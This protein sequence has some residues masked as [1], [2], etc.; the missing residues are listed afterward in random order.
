MQKYTCKQTENAYLLR[1]F[2]VTFV[3]SLSL[4]AIACLSTKKKTDF[5]SS[6]N[7]IYC[8]TLD[9][10]KTNGNCWR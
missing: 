3:S 2:A 4:V 7:C 1:Q 6:L 5:I 8:T 10:A 9:K